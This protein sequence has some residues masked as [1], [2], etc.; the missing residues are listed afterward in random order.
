MGRHS[1]GLVLLPA[2]FIRNHSYTHRALSFPQKIPVV[3]YYY[4]IC[5]RHLSTILCDA[6]VFLFYVNERGHSHGGGTQQTGSTDRLVRLAPVGE[7][8]WGTNQEKRLIMMSREGGGVAA[9]AW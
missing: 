2:I 1:Q 4:Q 6:T 9:V 8:G 5:Y 3:I 7:P